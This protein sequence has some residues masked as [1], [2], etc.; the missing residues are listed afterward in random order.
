MNELLFKFFYELPVWLWSTLFIIITLAFATLF[1]NLI[2]KL[3]LTKTLQHEVQLST[4]VMQLAG[5]IFAVLLALIVVSVFEQYS[6]VESVMFEEATYAGN[7][8]RDTFVIDKKNAEEIRQ[9]IYK[10]LQ[11]VINSE[12]PA[13]KKGVDEIKKVKVLG[14]QEIE[15]ILNIIAK[16]NQTPIIQGEMLNQAN[17]LLKY[18]RIRIGFTTESHLPK[19]IWI[20]LIIGALILTINLSLIQS[21]Q[22]FHMNIFCYIYILSIDLMLI[23]IIAYDR[24]FCGE[25]SVSTASYQQVMLTMKERLNYS[26]QLILDNKSSHS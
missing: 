2:D 8:F 14:N 25:L 15:D 1:N 21:E 13:Q 5:T 26:H 20:T 22:R 24:P 7:I 12:L 3:K 18:R 9:K 16:L 23:L 19:T 17:E 10:Y 11:L 4:A 6:K